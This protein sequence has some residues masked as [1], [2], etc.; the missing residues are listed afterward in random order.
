MSTNKRIAKRLLSAVLTVLMLMSM[1]TIGMASASAATLELAETGANLTGGEV[2]YLKPSSNWQSDGARFALYLFNN[3]TSTNTWVSMTKV[4]DPS[5]TVYTATVPTGDWAGLIFCRMNPSAALNDWTNKWNQTGDLTWNGTNNC[6]TVPAGTWDD[7]TTTWGTYTPPVVIPEYNVTFNDGHF[8]VTGDAKVTEG[9]DY[10]FTVEATTGFEVTK[11]TCNDAELT[12]VDGTYT[13]ADVKADLN[14]EITV[15]EIVVVKTYSVMFIDHDGTVISSETVEEN[16]EAKI[17]ADPTRP[18]YFFT[19]W[20]PA[21]EVTRDDET[22]KW[23]TVTDNAVFTAHYKEDSNDTPIITPPTQEE[24]EETS[25]WTVMFVDFDNTL[26]KIAKVEDGK[27][28]EAPEAPA[29]AGY[30]FKGWSQ[31]FD[32]VTADLLVVAQYK[33]NASTVVT[34]THG[35]LKLDVSGGTG[36]TMTIDGVSRPQG[37]TYFTNKMAIGTTITV[38][39]TTTNDTQFIGWTNASNGGVVSTSETYTLVTSGNDALKALYA[40]AVEGV[41][42]VVFNNDK[43][44]GGK[45]QILDMQYYASTDAINFPMD[46]SMIGYDF[47]GWSMTEAEI[48]AAIANGENVT[49]TPNWKRQEKYVD[50]T[51][52]GGAISYAAGT[53]AAGQVLANFKVTVTADAAEEGMKFAYWAVVNEE[54]IK[55]VSYATEYSFYPADAISLKAIFVEESA[56]IDY[57][58]LVG[59][60]YITTNGYKDTENEAR[61]SFN[62]SW[63]VPEEGMNVTF[64]KGGLL[65]VNADNYNESTFYIG[66]TDSNVYDKSPAGASASDTYGWTKKQIYNGDTWIIQPY[67][68]YVEDGETITVFGERVEY[69]RVDEI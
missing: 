13:V 19:G 41:G 31:S 14:I 34:P 29:R 30:T 54:T 65:A 57:Q 16:A 63:E 51:V 58:A 49:V 7:A 47:T 35:T 43:A 32:N 4:D 38:T 15:S 39:A 6:F 21:P 24:E 37:T 36:F 3:S 59:V 67:V 66:T 53:N 8:K 46:P 61:V 50:V 23:I 62:I 9:E 28:A 26:L 33:K 68:Q 17:P 69:T 56:V 27:A 20:T 60:N 52:E 22:G 25:K 18:G 2:L 11:V 12:A 44:L 42:L 1:V 40:T 55:T 5:V 10:T 48:Q 64:V 45:G